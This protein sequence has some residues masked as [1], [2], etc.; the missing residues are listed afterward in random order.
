MIREALRLRIAA[1][2]IE[3]IKLK[4]LRDAIEPA[5]QQVEHGECVPFDLDDV[6]SELDQETARGA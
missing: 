3:E 4:R 5:W 2:E 1:A 6:L